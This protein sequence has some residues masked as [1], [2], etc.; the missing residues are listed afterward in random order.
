MAKRRRKLTA[1]AAKR[2]LQQQGVSFNQ[3][4]HALPSS[5][6]RKILDAARAAGYRKRRDAPGSKARMFYQY[7]SRK[8][9]C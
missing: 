3:D 4:F 1:C 5:Q 8:R 6:V 9:G 2:R 7:L